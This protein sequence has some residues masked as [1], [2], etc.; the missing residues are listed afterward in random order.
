M[1]SVFIIQTQD[2]LRM[3]VVP[4]VDVIHIYSEYCVH[5][6]WK[7]DPDAGLSFKRAHLVAILAALK[8]CA[9]GHI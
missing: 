9:S 4:E 6:E 7:V 3:R 1:T 5:G 2:M 8:A